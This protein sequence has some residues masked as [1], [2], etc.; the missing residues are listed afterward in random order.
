MGG[1]TGQLFTEFSNSLAGAVLISGIVAYTLSPMMCSKVLNRE[2]KISKL[3]KFI[4]KVFSKIAAKY[5]A[6][7]MFFLDINHA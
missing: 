1:F 4:Y 5:K 7:L 6:L 2:M 3:V